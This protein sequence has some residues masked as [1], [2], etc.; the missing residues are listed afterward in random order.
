[1][2]KS[3][4]RKHAI[5]GKRL[6]RR[7]FLRLLGVGAATGL[8]FGSG[9]C[10]AQPLAEN[11]FTSGPKSLHAEQWGMVIDTR[12]L[13]E[14]ER[15]GAVIRACHHSHNIPAVP[16]PQDVK[17]IWHD[18]LDAAFT[19]DLDEFMPR[20][21]REGR[22][23]L[24]C[25]HC[26]NPACTRVCPTGA[27][28]RRDDGIVVMDYHRCV[29]CRYCMAA[30]PYGSR[31]FNYQEP[32]QYLEEITP[33]Y[34]PRMR[35]V[36]EKCTFCMERLAVGKMPLC[37]EASEGAIIFGDLNDPASPVRKALEE[38]VALRRKP[39]LGTLP[40]VYYIL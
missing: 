32:R 34:P 28:F 13:Q 7:R 12:R 35:G 30:C 3:L 1:M 8:V 2:K 20:A 33:E 40:C 36:V 21:V 37:V 22:F 11:A 27:T 10:E 18:G 17:W 6:P 9:A 31:S 19:D 29:G 15:L 38:N 4:N 39:A 24:L 23:L 16:P 26:A 5:S 25:N 14:P